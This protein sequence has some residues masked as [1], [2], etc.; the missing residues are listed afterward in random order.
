MHVLKLAEM[1]QMYLTRLSSLD[2][3]ERSVD[4]QTV[5]STR[6]KQRV[7][8]VKLRRIK[9]KRT[10]ERENDFEWT[11]QRKKENLKILSLKRHYVHF[12]QTTK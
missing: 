4:T 8:Y 12:K 9:H 2:Q 1:W 3:Y 5:F 7:T 6:S 11:K 10:N